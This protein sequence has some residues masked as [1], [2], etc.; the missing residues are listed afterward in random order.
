L[1]VASPPV[2]KYLRVQPGRNAPRGELGGSNYRLP[3]E[4]DLETLS[5]EIDEAM[6]QK[7]SLVIEVEME[8]EPLSHPSLVL[9]C[10][11]IDSVLIGDTPEPDVA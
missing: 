10:A 6:T 2:A 5:Q 9:N 4:T 1:P 7:T 11:L 8:D 3:A